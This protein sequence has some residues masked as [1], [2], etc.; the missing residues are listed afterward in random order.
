MNREANSSKLTP[1]NG[2]TRING[3]SIFQHGQE[4]EGERPMETDNVGQECHNVSN[5]RHIA[6]QNDKKVVSNS[7]PQ[8][9]GK[10]TSTE[11]KSYIDRTILNEF[12]PVQPD[13]RDHDHHGH[14]GNHNQ[15]VQHGHP[16]NN[17]PHG[18]FGNQGQQSMAMK[19][20][21][22]AAEASKQ[23]L[24]GVYGNVVSILEEYE[25]RTQKMKAERSKIELPD[26]SRKTVEDV[27]S[28]VQTQL[29]LF[30][31]QQRACPKDVSASVNKELRKKTIHWAAVREE[32][33]MEVSDT[34]KYICQLYEVL[35]KGKT[36]HE[37]LDKPRD[38]V[39]PETIRDNLQHILKGKHDASEIDKQ[40]KK[41]DTK[42]AVSPQTR[43]SEQAFVTLQLG[44]TRMSQTMPELVEVLDEDLKEFGADGPETTS[45]LR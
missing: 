32:H 12:D 20:M 5:K 21:Q 42:K 10:S 38:P 3:D 36:K 35:V 19:Q 7:N 2:R 29:L 9:A 17:D 33:K 1:G 4:E 37:I 16:G 31:T 13:Y 45:E 41:D 22:R 11:Q 40:F 15:H 26:Q 30:E 34:D 23:M 25:A 28:I 43:R 39:S 44:A 6:Q 18:Q 14:H 24:Y 8:N 27:Q